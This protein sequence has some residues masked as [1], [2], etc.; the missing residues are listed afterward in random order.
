MSTHQAGP[1]G[2]RKHRTGC[3]A[4]WCANPPEAAL[5]RHSRTRSC[6]TPPEADVEGQDPCW[7]PGAQSAASPSSPKPCTDLGNTFLLP[8]SRWA[9]EATAL[10]PKPS[11]LP[12]LQ[13]Y[14]HS[15]PVTTEHARADQLVSSTGCQL[16]EGPFLFC[17]F[18]WK[19]D[20]EEVIEQ[21][22][23]QFLYYSF[24][25]SM[26]KRLNLKTFRKTPCQ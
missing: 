23:G 7:A 3:H 1:F 20:Y 10:Q 12:P 5:R 14:T 2:L 15:V 17:S 13:L 6:D 16:K 24:L 18:L 9:R 8:C 21:G 4:I 19:A 22:C 25:K 26:R 11:H